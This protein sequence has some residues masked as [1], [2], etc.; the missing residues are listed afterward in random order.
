M[1]IMRDGFSAFGHPTRGLSNAKTTFQDY[2][3]SKLV[4]MKLAKKSMALQMNFQLF[5]HISGENFHLL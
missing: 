4:I 3:N 2:H 1:S 5:I